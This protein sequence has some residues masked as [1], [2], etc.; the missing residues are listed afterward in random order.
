MNK[1]RLL[2]LNSASLDLV[3]PFDVFRR[4][5]TICAIASRQA[6]QECQKFMA[7]LQLMALSEEDK[8]ENQILSKNELLIGL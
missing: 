1:I 8:P 4:R 7:L 6:D 5:Y 2:A 3:G